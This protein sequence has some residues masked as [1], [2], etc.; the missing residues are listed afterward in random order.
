[1]A[2]SP[3]PLDRETVTFLDISMQRSVR[4]V[5]VVRESG[6]LVVVPDRFRLGNWSRYRFG[7]AVKVRQRP[8]GTP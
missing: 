1:M 6:C 8:G 2:I 7:G 4:C 5:C 3:H